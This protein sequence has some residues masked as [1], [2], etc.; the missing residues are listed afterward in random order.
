MKRGKGGGGWVGGIRCE[1]RTVVLIITVNLCVCM[2]EDGELF[3][4]VCS[5]E[6]CM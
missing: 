4:T 1:A 6:R 5:F 3:V 2:S